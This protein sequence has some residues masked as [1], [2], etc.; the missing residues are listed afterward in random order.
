MRSTWRMAMI[1]ALAVVGLSLP[2]LRPRPTMSLHPKGLIPAPPPHSAA[3]AALR[4]AQQYR[5]RARIAVSEQQ[6]GLE[7]WDPQ[8]SN[9]M[10]ADAWRLQ[11]LALDRH[12]NLRQARYWARQAAL[13]A[14]T[15]ADAY[16]VAELQVLLDHEAGD[17]DA[18]HKE[19]QRLITLAPGSGRARMVLRRAE[20]C[21]RT[22][23]KIR[24]AG[25]RTVPG[26]VH[27]A[28]R[29]PSAY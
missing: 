23:Q 10:N 5:T 26:T 11:Q 4:R 13:L 3:E 2:F 21:Y 27:P 25:R 28:S 6:S 22:R 12:G 8:A 20:A 14:R 9:A 1:G 17:H 29:L 24:D 18:E 15:Q 7:A 16:H 19:A